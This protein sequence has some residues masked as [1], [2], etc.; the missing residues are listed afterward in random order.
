MSHPVLRPADLNAFP[1]GHDETME[2]ISGAVVGGLEWWRPQ[3]QMTNPNKVYDGE[4]RS[5]QPGP[6]GLRKARFGWMVI[7]RSSPVRLR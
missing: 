3:V 1:P 6:L 2:E 5:G 4:E 7:C